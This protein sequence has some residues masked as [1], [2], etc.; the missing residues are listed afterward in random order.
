MPQGQSNIPIQES[1]AG[2]AAFVNPADHRTLYFVDGDTPPGAACSGS[3]TAEW[4]VLTVTA[5]SQPQG[6]L[7]IVTRTDGTKQWSFN[8]HALYEFAG[9][10][11]P[12]QSNGVYG[13]W[14]IAR[15]AA[16]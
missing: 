7:T 15:P 1:V 4:P 11:G 3:C 13:P 16:H 8:G 6:S 12:D 5:G 10:F 2:A 14:H 9:D